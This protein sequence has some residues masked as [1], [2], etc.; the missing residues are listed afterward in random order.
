MLPLSSLFG[1]VLPLN[2]SDVTLDLA[3][4]IIKKEFP[5]IWKVCNVKSIDCPGNYSGFKAVA[6][7]C[8]SGVIEVLMNDKA[9]ANAA[10][11]ATML[12]KYNF[13]TYYVSRNVIAAM[14]HT[15]PPKNMTWGDIHF[16][17]GGLTFM[18]P[19]GS[20]KDP[21]EDNR[22]VRL[23]SVVKRDQNDLPILGTEKIARS[24]S[25]A[26]ISVSWAGGNC[27]TINDATVS[28]DKELE[29]DPNWMKETTEKY[30]G[31]NGFENDPSDPKFSC[32]MLAIAANLLLLMQTRKQLVNDGPPHPDKRKIH[33]KSGIPIQ[34]PIWLG[35]RYEIVDR[36]PKSTPTG[37]YFTE[38]DWR[39]GHFRRQH[40]G[41]SGQDVK[42]VLIDPYIAHVRGLVRPESVGHDA[43][44]DELK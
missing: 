22:D 2:A 26:G 33:P 9:P 17:F 31:I 3:A 7:A 15:H 10:V 13:P 23:I 18:L 44:V 30:R 1:K 36:R 41:K 6:V 32:R 38:I 40:H 21:T 42:T 43:C 25:N 27:L 24:M 28:L 16:P 5:S 8:A 35:H 34:K 29:P 39:A 20:I 14:G 4:D 11:V 12:S 19:L 37:A